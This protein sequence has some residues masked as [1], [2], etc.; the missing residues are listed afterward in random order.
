MPWATPRRT[1]PRSRSAISPVASVPYAQTASPLAR[2]APRRE[3]RAGEKTFLPASTVAGANARKD[4]K[5][6]QLAP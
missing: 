5:P 1:V 3:I 6:D 4:A 2:N